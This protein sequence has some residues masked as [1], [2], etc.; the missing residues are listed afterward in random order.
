[1]KDG[2]VEGGEGWTDGWIYMS[3][4][5]SLNQRTAGCLSSAGFGFLRVLEKLFHSSR[6]LQLI[7]D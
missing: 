3:V 5:T 1:M 7:A 6:G 2:L 4:M